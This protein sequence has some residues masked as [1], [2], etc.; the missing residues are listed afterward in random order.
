VRENVPKVAQARREYIEGFVTL[1]QL[2]DRHGISF[3][4][5]KRY[6]ADEGWV[7]LRKAAREAAIAAEVEE[8]AEMLK[9]H[10]P[11]H[12]R[13]M[14]QLSDAAAQAAEDEFRKTGQVNPVTGKP[15]R[16]DAIAAS[17][18][19][20]TSIECA[21]QAHGLADTVGEAQGMGKLSIRVQEDPRR[22]KQLAASSSSNG[23]STNGHSNG[24]SNGS[25]TPYPRKGGS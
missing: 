16:T 23:S 25:S 11:H 6:S 12:I 18:A 22:L 19:A 8:A 13:Q 21:R 15:L 2:A 20:R 3:R 7:A 17:A 4:Q 14:V 1:E 24:N 5:L 10:R 9:A